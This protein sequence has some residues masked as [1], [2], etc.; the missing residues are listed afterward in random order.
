VPLAFIFAVSTVGGWLIGYIKEKQAAGSIIP[1]WIAHAT[2]NV[3][4]YAIIA[5]VI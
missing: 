1:G 5:F 3:L 2:A 4:S